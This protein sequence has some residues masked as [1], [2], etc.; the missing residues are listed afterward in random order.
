MKFSC[1]LCLAIHTAEFTL[2]KSSVKDVRRLSDAPLS[3]SLSLT[4]SQGPVHRT[5]A[6][7]VSLPVADL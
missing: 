1:E 5:R 3:V 4:S 7:T 2:P 6:V